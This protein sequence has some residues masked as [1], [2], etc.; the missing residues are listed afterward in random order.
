[1]EIDDCMMIEDDD[2]IFVSQ[3]EDFL[4][5]KREMVDPY[6]D[7]TPTPSGKLSKGNGNN[8]KRISTVIVGPYFVGELLGKGGFGEVREGTN[9]LTGDKI[10]LKFIKKSE[11]QS[12]GAVERAANEIKCLTIL[13]HANIIKLEMVS[14]VPSILNFSVVNNVSV[15]SVVSN[16]GVLRNF[17]IVSNA[18]VVSVVGNVSG[19]SNVSVVGSFS[20]SRKCLACPYTCLPL[21]LPQHL[22]I[23]RSNFSC[24]CLS[25]C[26]YPSTYS[27]LCRLDPKC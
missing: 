6:D 20:V 13:R 27:I 19:V 2:R 5:P 10:A 9:Q 21:S 12:M 4:Q 18:I 16:A 7:C 15:V 11:I 22:I 23:V 3:G 14:C 8:Q 1:M 25:F 17:S 24:D 26:F